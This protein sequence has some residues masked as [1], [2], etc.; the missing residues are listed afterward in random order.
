[1]MPLGRGTF[2]VVHPCSTF[3]DNWRHH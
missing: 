1:L 3:W 2:V